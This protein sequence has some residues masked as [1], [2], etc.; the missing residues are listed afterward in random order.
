MKRLTIDLIFA[1][2]LLIIAIAGPA[3]PQWEGRATLTGTAVIYGSGFNTRTVTRTFTMHLERTTPPSEA[4]R[5]LSV[6]ESK[7]QD[8]L[9]RA[10]SGNDLGRFSLGGR[11]GEPLRAVVVDDHNGLKRIRAVFQRWIGFGEFRRGYRS[12]DYPFSYVEILLDPRTG[13]GDGTFFPAARIRFREANRNRPD[14]VEIEDFGT[15]PGRLMG[16]RLRGT[17]LP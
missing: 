5:L 2:L 8:G 17:R 7:G 1:A 13:S 12:I 3:Y 14:T 10:M 6:L 11:V 4:A 15:F 9:L 16:V